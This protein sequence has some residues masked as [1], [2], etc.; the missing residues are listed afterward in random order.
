M[1]KEFVRG[2]LLTAGLG[3]SLM[4]TVASADTF[5]VNPG[6][7]GASGPTV[8]S[9][10]FADFSYV[11]LVNQTAT[12]GTGTFNE[13][14]AGFFSSYRFPTLSD[15]VPN[16]GIN[17]NYKLYAVF[18]GGGTVAPTPGIPGGTTATFNNFN[19]RLFVDR[20]MNSTITASPV[21]TVGGTV[22]V[23]NTADDVLVGQSTGLVAGE[24]HAFPGLANGDFKVLVNFTPVGGFLSGPFVAGLTIGT[25]NGV[26]TS[27]TGFSMGNFNSG[28][29]DGSGNLSF[30][31]IPEPASLLLV[32]SGLAALGWM[33]R[34]HQN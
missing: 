3:L 25:F 15:V 1:F 27:L 33:R 24:A 14:G 12:A 4:V 31:A 22:S 19:L 17:T 26:N 2:S 21:G 7:I 9:V 23:A 32:G 11:A 18:T 28:R 13:Q 20:D 6:A 5:T 8:P 29:I 34:R 10:N 30:S 16:S